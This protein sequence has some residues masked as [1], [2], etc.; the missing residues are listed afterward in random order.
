MV[1]HFKL[2]FILLSNFDWD[3]LTQQEL[4]CEEAPLPCSRFP[5]LCGKRVFKTVRITRYNRRIW[6]RKFMMACRGVTDLKG[7]L[8]S[9]LIPF[10]CKVSNKNLFCVGIGMDGFLSKNYLKT[11]LQSM[12]LVPMLLNT[13]VGTQLH[14]SGTHTSQCKT[15][16]DLGTRL[17]MSY[18]W[19]LVLLFASSFK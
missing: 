2:I 10:Q 15:E 17:S 5:S 18:T 3:R 7:A 9:G 8:V 4:L 6:S 12:R 19:S 13:V 16:W 11:S 1:R 14:K